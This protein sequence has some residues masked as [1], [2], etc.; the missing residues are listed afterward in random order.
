MA[1][2]YK[3]GQHRWQARWRMRDGEEHARTF[4]TRRDAERH[5]DKVRGDLLAG[6]YIDPRAGQRLFADY[7]TEW[8]ASR[9]HSPATRA[10][11]ESHMERHVLPTFGSR[12]I[13]SVTP[14]LVQG[15]V[16]RL[17]ETL[18]PATVE[19]VFRHTASVFK[20]AVSDGLIARSPCVTVKLPRRERRLVVPLETEEVL[21][22]AGAATPRYRAA[23]LVAAGTGLRQAEL[24]G[25]TVD[26][27]D[28]PRRRL[29]VEQQLLTLKGTPSFGPPK[30]IASRRTIPLPDVVLHELVAQVRDFPDSDDARRL[31]FTSRDGGPVRRNTASDAWHR[32]SD[33]AKRVRG[34]REGW[35]ALRHYY[36]SLLIRHGESVKVVQARLGHASAS[37]T[38]D[39][40]AHL[41]PDSDDLTREAVDEVLGAFAGRILAVSPRSESL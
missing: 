16:R 40:Y 38:L 4:P 39:T 36:A 13:A 3:R 1:H 30:T 24:F 18:A 2:I 22:L 11:V 10:Q 25:L 21:A 35:H 7:L 5:L 29:H 14:T 19:V 26:H 33:R 23:F 15:W 27:I 32:A 20:C 37:E 34:D 28:F 12:P 6:T 17:A 9:L 31:V 41:W 8:K